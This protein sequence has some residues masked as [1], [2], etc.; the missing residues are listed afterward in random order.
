MMIS[1][2]EKD[3]GGIWTI[4]VTG[5]G[6]LI[7]YSVVRKGFTETRLEIPEEHER[8]SHA[9]IWRVILPG[10]GNHKFKHPRIQAA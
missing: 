1:A 8:L 3:K 10:R 9:I 7:L 2:L 4:R 5:W 6:I